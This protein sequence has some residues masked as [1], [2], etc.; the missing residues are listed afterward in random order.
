MKTYQWTDY[1]C[2]DLSFYER[3]KVE[4]FDHPDLLD[5]SVGDQIHYKS[6]VLNANFVV[7]RVELAN[8]RDYDE[9]LRRV[10]ARVEKIQE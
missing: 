10:Q 8:L 7:F 4:F 2:P 5:L 6:L 9:R 1:T 3:D